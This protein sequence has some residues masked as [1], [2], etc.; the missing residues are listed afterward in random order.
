MKV[1]KSKIYGIGIL[2]IMLSLSLGIGRSYYSG[3]LPLISESRI[4]NKV[5]NV[6]I[7]ELSPS[8]YVRYITDD[9][10]GLIDTKEIGRY[11]FELQYKPIDFLALRFYNKTQDKKNFQEEIQNRIGLQYYTLKIGLTDSNNDIMTDNLISNDDYYKR[12]EYFSFGIQRDLKVVSNRDTF[13]CKLLHFERVYGLTQYITFT[14]GFEANDSDKKI[15]EKVFIYD[16]K[17]FSTGTI[18]LRIKEEALSNIPKLI[19]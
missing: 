1:K 15:Y 6:N 12:V 13:D 4:A 3:K 10:N 16:D 9:E 7:Q 8:D 2:I 5:N 14:L 19:I 17:I 11:K 18:K